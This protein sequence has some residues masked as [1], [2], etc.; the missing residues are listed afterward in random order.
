[1]SLSESQIAQIRDDISVELRCGLQLKKTGRAA[2]A[3]IV[4]NQLRG[5]RAVIRRLDDDSLLHYVDSAINDL[6]EA[7]SDSIVFKESL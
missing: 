3:D 5:M 6:G 2:A 1:M 7:K 4:E